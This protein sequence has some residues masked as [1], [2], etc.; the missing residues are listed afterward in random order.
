MNE[1]K[2]QVKDPTDAPPAGKMFAKP[3]NSIIDT[4]AR[5]SKS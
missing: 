4:Y 3:N 1:F 5:K 2:G